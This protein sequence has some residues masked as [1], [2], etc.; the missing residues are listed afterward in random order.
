M[1]LVPV[2]KVC[3]AGQTH[4]IAVAWHLRRGVT[5]ASRCS[6]T[7]ALLCK[8]ITLP[9]ANW[10]QHCNITTQWCNVTMW[11]HRSVMGFLG[12]NL[13]YVSG[14]MLQNFN[15]SKKNVIARS[16]HW[17]LEGRDISLS[18]SLVPAFFLLLSGCSLQW[19]VH[20]ATPVEDFALWWTNRQVRRGIMDTVV[21]PWLE[22]TLSSLCSMQQLFQKSASCGL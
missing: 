20:H 4:C 11:G 21:E 16:T 7:C 13:Q 22:L 12:G 19:R 18:F 14:Y 9:Q 8:A 6:S 3:C 10:G 15:L 17:E 1:G 2:L 5:F